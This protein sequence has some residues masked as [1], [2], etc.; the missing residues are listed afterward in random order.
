MFIFKQD[1]NFRFYFK[2][3]CEVNCSS[4]T[5]ARVHAIS[6]TFDVNVKDD[7]VQEDVFEHKKYKMIATLNETFKFQS[8]AIRVN[9]IEIVNENTFMAYRNV[10]NRS[11]LYRIATTSDEE[12]VM[13]IEELDRCFLIK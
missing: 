7:I 11:Y 6:S 8:A 4:R 12:A 3:R 10:E 13:P 5:D 2:K 9:D 1:L